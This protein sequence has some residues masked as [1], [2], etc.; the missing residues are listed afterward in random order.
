MAIKVYILLS[1][2]W[3]CDSVMVFIVTLCS[4]KVCVS[5]PPHQVWFV[6]YVIYSRMVKKYPNMPYFANNWSI[7]PSKS[8]VLSL[9]CVYDEIVSIVI[10]RLLYVEVY[11]QYVGS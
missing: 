5:P 1:S 2:V 11:V 10:L 9:K 6:S 3:L 7:M 8:L 4:S